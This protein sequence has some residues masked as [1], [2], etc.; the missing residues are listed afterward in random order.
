MDKRVDFGVYHHSSRTESEELRKTIVSLFDKAA[1]KLRIEN[2]AEKFTKCLDAGCG[3]GFVSYILHES[4]KNTHIWAIDNFKDSSLENN[5]VEKTVNNFERLGITDFITVVK[6]D[7]KKIPYTD[8]Y[9]D[10]A[11]S[12]LVYHN[13]GHDLFLGIK[14]IYRVLKDDG[15]FL[16]GDIF[17]E[18]NIN[19]IKALFNVENTLK[20]EYMK[21]YSLL[22]LSKK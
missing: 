14:E 15:I 20:P 2:D 5:S 17:I 19:Q 3:S 8:G 10:L 4:F 16:Y 12:S 9:F 7:L 22:M 11:A 21:E 13:F 18:K 6:A 1:E